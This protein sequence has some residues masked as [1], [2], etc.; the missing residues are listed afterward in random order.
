ME[1]I[2]DSHIKVLA[3]IQLCLLQ[4]VEGFI[5]ILQK[6]KTNMDFVYKSHILIL[7]IIPKAW[8]NSKGERIGYGSC[9]GRVVGF[10]TLAF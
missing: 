8:T 6:M 1:M 7:N 3:Y 9:G 4:Y 2:Q 5:S 10:Q